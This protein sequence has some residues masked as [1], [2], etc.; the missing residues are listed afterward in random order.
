MWTLRFVLCSSIL[1]VAV[2]VPAGCAAYKAASP[3]KSGSIP[4]P[5]GYR[6]WPHVKSM[7]IRQGHPLHESFGGIH[8]VYANE[9]AR[10]ALQAGRADY[11]D[12]AVF[13]FDLLAAEEAGGAITEGPRKVLG[14][15]LRDRR[16]FAETGGWG[17]AAF[18]PGAKG[19]APP[20][21]AAAC[22]NCHAAQ[23]SES[24]YVFSRWR[25]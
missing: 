5:E 18:A 10:R 15:M 17:F 1:S 22:F 2:L 13:V 19:T 6:S 4:Y 8:H 23:A 3:S 11:P 25:D 14:V 24:G 20:Q 16:A 9:P 12:G 7:V 21:P